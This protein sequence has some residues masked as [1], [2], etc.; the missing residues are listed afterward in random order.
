MNRI[1]WFRPV[2]AGI[3]IWLPV[4]WALEIPPGPLGQLGAEDF[5]TREKAQAE[6]VDWA[7]LQPEAAMEV[8]YQQSRNATDPEIR[9]RCIAVLRILVGDEYLKDGEGYIGIRMQ[10][11][12]ANVPGDPKPRGVIR[13]IQVVPGSAAEAAGLKLN[14]LIAG[15]N[16]TVW[17]E[18]SIAFAFGDKIRQFKP[19][20]KVTLKILREGKLIDVEV[21]LGRRPLFAEN[22]FLNETDEDIAE[23]EKAAR[24]AYFR[25]WLDERKARN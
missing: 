11:E 18:E 2:L 7:R 5:R 6:I 24:E 23:A 16:D 19:N 14:D 12:I 3:L 25:R 10:D 20:T 8:L 4:S 13:V 9:E 15:L 17:H 21:K 1:G 22:P